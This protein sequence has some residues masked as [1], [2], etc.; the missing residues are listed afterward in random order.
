MA[1]CAFIISAWASKY[2]Y[3][4]YLC[5]YCCCML[6]SSVIHH[7][8][9]QKWIPSA[10]RSGGSPITAICSYKRHA[11]FRE[12]DMLSIIVVLTCFIKK[13]FMLSVRML[14][15]L[16][17][18]C[19]FNHYVR[20]QDIISLFGLKCPKIAYYC[21]F[22]NFYHTISSRVVTFVGIRCI[23]YIHWYVMYLTISLTDELLINII[24]KTNNIHTYLTGFCVFDHRSVRF[25]HWNL[26]AVHRNVPQSSKR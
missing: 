1:S 21:S 6:S 2:K 7:G 5:C 10:K 25:A 3:T 26:H 20:W 13:L 15:I 17:M 22:G 18:E 19:I 4:V 12:T 9:M 8:F 24:V 23:Q 11:V 14:T 16:H